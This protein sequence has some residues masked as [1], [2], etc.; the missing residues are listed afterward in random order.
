[1][2]VMI[3]GYLIL[4]TAMLMTMGLIGIALV[5]SIIVMSS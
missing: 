1:M 5:G 3:V 4:K 2:A